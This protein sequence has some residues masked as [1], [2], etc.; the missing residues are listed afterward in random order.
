VL[1]SPEHKKIRTAVENHARDIKKAVRSLTR[2]G[3][4]PV[5]PQALWKRVLLDEVVDF[6]EINAFFFSTKLDLDPTPVSTVESALHK[7]LGRSAERKTVS[8]SIIWFRCFDKYSE[9]VETVF[10]YRTSELRVW[11]RHI[12]DLFTAKID[13]SQTRVIAYDIAARKVIASN[14]GILFNQCNR[15]RARQTPDGVS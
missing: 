14:P 12:D 5:F 8:T 6:D 9:A 3:A 4:A 10:P 2:T 7:A 15:C 1:L 13:E 11:R